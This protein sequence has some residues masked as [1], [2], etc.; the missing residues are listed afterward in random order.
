[1]YIITVQKK[2]EQILNIYGF[3]KKLLDEHWGLIHGIF[4][5]LNLYETLLHILFK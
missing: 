4:I 3:T 2:N 5:N 1:M